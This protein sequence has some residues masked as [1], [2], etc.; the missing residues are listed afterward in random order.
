MDNFPDAT[1][2][3][4][5]NYCRNPNEIDGVGPW[6]FTTDPSMPWEGCDIPICSLVA[7]ED[8][9]KGDTLILTKAGST[10]YQ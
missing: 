3:E 6:C 5:A 1:L 2:G 10:I 7:A 4:A 8:V 9:P